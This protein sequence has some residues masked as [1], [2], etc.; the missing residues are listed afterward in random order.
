MKPHVS[1]NEDF[2]QGKVDDAISEMINFKGDKLDHD[3][4]K[5]CYPK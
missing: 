3:R 2:F 1:V 5:S 4:F